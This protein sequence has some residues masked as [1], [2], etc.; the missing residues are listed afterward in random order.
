MLT[1]DKPSRPRRPAIKRYARHISWSLTSLG[2]ILVLAFAFFGSPRLAGGLQFQVF[3]EDLEAVSALA[4]DG[5]G[6]LYATLEKR[7]GQGQLVHIGHGETQ[8]VLGGLD[9]PDGIL[10]RDGALYL[11]SEDGPHGLLAYASGE[12]RDLDGAFGAE[13]IAGAGS[14]KILV[15]EDR[16]PAGRLLR[17]DPA[18][19][20]IEVLLDG[21]QQAEG[22]CET[23]GGEIYYVEKTSDR[24][25]RYADGQ[26]VAAATGLTKPAF[27]NCLADGSILITED[28]TNFGRLLRYRDGTMEVLARNLGA[29]QSVVVGPD[30]AYY[31]AEQRNNRILKIYGF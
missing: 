28:R 18:T 16:K 23:P 25:S 10:L 24:L 12:R 9:K 20:E 5:N 30:G 6:G 2:L 7:H 11:T 21:L 26:S 8:E 14:D 29:P 3:A 31:L 4:F 22:V 13:G 1:L 15:I 27:L 17:I 19:A